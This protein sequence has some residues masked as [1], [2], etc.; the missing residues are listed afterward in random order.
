MTEA[1]NLALR[2]TAYD[3]RLAINQLQ[4]ELNQT[5]DPQAVEGMLERLLQMQVGLQQTEQAIAASERE[6]PQSG[7]ILTTRTSSSSRT[8]VTRGAATTGLEAKVNLHMA[9]IP[10]AIYHL[11]DK[12][13]HPLFVCNIKNTSNTKRRVRVTSHL[14]NYSAAAVY[15]TELDP[16]KDEDI[17]QLPTLFPERIN[18]VNELTRATLNVQVDDLDTGKIEI[19]RTAPLWLLSRN[20]APLAVKDPTTGDWNDLTRYLAAFVT[21]NEPSVIE[22]HRKVVERHPERRLVGYQKDVD[23]QVKAIFDALKEDTGIVYVNSVI[24]FNPEEGSKTQRIRLPRQSLHERQANCI[25]GVVLFASLLEGIS[26]NPAIVVL[27]KHVIIGWETGN[28]SG[29]WRYLESTK[30]G[31]HSFEEAVKFGE[32]LAKGYAAQRKATNNP[33]WFRQWSLRDVRTQ[34][35]QITPME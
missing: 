7:V 10:T 6:D 21:P 24:D 20:S 33:A 34:K 27:P 15:T 16:Y 18:H 23:S 4:R 2:Q 31:T 19:H 32:T 5:A 30:L 17:R 1:E 22:F 11:L 35:P 28:Q 14:D 29:E 9:Q 8:A 25:D 12:D 26:L 3:L 13:E